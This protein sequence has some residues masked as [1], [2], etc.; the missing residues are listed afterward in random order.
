[1]PEDGEKYWLED[2]VLLKTIHW[3]G[4]LKHHPKNDLLSQCLQLFAV[5]AS[6]VVSCLKSLSFIHNPALNGAPIVQYSIDGQKLTR[7]VIRTHIETITA[8][9]HP[10][11]RV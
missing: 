9:Y 7:L 3:R 10:Q 2:G 8:A 11:Q 5:T 6:M 1:M 4:T